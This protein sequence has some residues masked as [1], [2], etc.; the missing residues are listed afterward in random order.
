MGRA[1]LSTRPV[2][3]SSPDTIPPWKA[4][5]LDVLAEMLKAFG[6]PSAV[7]P[8]MQFGDRETGAGSRLHEALNLVTDS[9]AVCCSFRS[10]KEMAAETQAVLHAAANDKANPPSLVSGHRACGEL[11]HKEP[12]V[13]AAAARLSSSLKR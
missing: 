11:R 12:S 7:W 10:R 5:Q 9:G 3:N 4:P 1:V 8:P 13:V 6:A 2:L